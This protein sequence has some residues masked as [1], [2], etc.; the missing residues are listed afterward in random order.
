MA[1]NN[2]NYFNPLSSMESDIV[3]TNTFRILVTDA[4]GSD[5]LEA[6]CKKIMVKFPNSAPVELQWISGFANFSGRME[7]PIEFSGTFYTGVSEG[8]SLDSLVQWRNI[9]LNFTSGRIGLANE[10]KRTGSILWMDPSMTNPIAEIKLVAMWPK[11]IDDIQLD[12]STNEAVEVSATFR[13]DQMIPNMM[14]S[15]AV[16][17]NGSAY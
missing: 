15:A 14:A 16:L 6:M 13:A 8:N 1:F 12:V 4:P 11:S 2:I 10:Y 5:N 17:N 3:R 9:C 7:G